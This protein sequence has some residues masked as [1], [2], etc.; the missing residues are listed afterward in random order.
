[1]NR[2]VNEPHHLDYAAQPKT[3]KRIHPL[4]RILVGILAL[5]C[6]VPTINIFAGF[7]PA[8]LVYKCVGVIVTLS[9]AFVLG[10]ISLT[11]R[12]RIR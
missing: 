8:G 6:V 11:G 7:D 3:R 2:A 1:M 10:F 4:I 12:L 9:I 5:L